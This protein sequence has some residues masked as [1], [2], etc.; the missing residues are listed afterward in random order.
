MYDFKLLDKKLDEFL[1]L[2][3]PFYDCKVMK[4]GECV[5]RKKNG[6]TDN[7]KTLKPTGEEIYNL[8]S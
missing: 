6:F 2:G 5:Y 4:N 8:Y 1:K 3:I 7:S